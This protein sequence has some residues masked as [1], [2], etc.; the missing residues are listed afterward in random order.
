MI[1]DVLQSFGRSGVPLY[2]VYAPSGSPPE[3]LPAILTPRIVIDAVA[4]AEAT[5]TAGS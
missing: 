1:A 5:R 3:V 4:R 2:V